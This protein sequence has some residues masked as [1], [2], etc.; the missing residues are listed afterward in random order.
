ML[1]SYR[2]IA[3]VGLLFGPALLMAA[4]DTLYRWDDAK[5]NPVISDRPPPVGTP[6][7]T[8]DANYSGNRRMGSIK[9]PSATAPSNVPL[10][11]VPASSTAGSDASQAPVKK[12]PTL[13]QEAQDNIFKLETFARIRME[14]PVTGE[15]RF[16][17]DEERQNQL[18]SARAQTEIHCD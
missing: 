17:S 15:I 5:G 6:Y 14:D 13:C 9:A 11:R 12:N 10:P 4:S 7:S 1:K 3:L 2:Q 8:L 18:E 16:L